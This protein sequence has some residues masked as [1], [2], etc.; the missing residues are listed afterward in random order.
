MPRAYRVR[1][2]RRKSGS[3]AL[4][5]FACACSKLRNAGNLW[6]FSRLCRAV[7]GMITVL[8]TV[9]SILAFRL[10]RRNSL[11]PELIGLRHQVR[12]SCSGSTRVGFGYSPP[13]DFSGIGFTGF[14][15]GSSTPWCWS[16]RQPASI[17]RR[18]DFRIY[19]GWRSRCPGPARDDYS[20]PIHRISL[21]NA[22]APA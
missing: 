13:T 12:V 7:A 10:R 22:K 2:S 8:S 19:W 15:C 3:R 6:R 11:E 4:V 16:S 21:A 14:G 5:K 20:D 9:V 1:L 18:N 17:G